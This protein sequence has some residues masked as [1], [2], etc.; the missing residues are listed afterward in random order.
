[1]SAEATA[2]TVLASLLAA[3]AGVLAGYVLSSSRERGREVSELRSKLERLSGKTEASGQMAP[4]IQ[5]QVN[6][7]LP[8]STDAS[9]NVGT[10]TRALPSQEE[11]EKRLFEIEDR[12]GQLEVESVET[13]A[14]AGSFHGYEFGGQ[15][16]SQLHW[17]ARWYETCTID[18]GLLLI[19]VVEADNRLKLHA[20]I[21]GEPFGVLP[22]RSHAVDEALKKALLQLNVTPEG[23]TLSLME[24]GRELLQAWQSWGAQEVSR[25]EG[26]EEG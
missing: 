9:S 12:L 21:E 10:S 1:M 23:P 15:F 11:I 2:I 5:Q 17:F 20:A 8:T 14:P 22:S 18:V 26:G 6:V 13:R 19:E 4:A 7:S 3:L 24:K 16:M 25:V